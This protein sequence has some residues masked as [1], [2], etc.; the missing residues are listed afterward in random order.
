MADP[1][2]K[3]PRTSQ[4]VP[5][6]ADA[7]S[8]NP[9]TALEK[10]AKSLAALVIISGAAWIV[11]GRAVDA[12]FILDDASS[13][14]QNSSIRKL[15]PLFGDPAVP[16]P[17]RPPQNAATSG[18]PLVNLSLAANY[19]F[20]RLDPGGYHVFNIVVHVFSAILLWAIV[21]RTLCLEFFQHDFDRVARPLAF[22]V[23]LVW[24]IHP[25]QTETVVYVTQ[26]S[27]L[28]VGFFYL[29]TL[30]ASLRYWSSTS[31]SRH[32]TWLILASLAC[33]SGA[34]CKEV[35]VSAPVIVLLF[36]RTFV[37]GSF[38][39]AVRE[40]WPLYLGLLFSWC[41][42]LALNLGWP[43][44]AT[45]GFHLGVPAHAWWLT[46]AK[47]FVT[48]LKLSIYPWPLVLHY[49]FE[50]FYTLGEAWPWVVPVVLLA[51][52]A[53]LLFW[54]R[55]ATGFGLLCI[56]A[57]LSPTLVI[58][59]ITEVAAERRMYLPLAIV[60]AVAVVASY[61]L[62][63]VV[64]GRLKPASGRTRQRK[65]LTVRGDRPL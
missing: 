36:E 6:S 16:G 19:H 59:V 17:L 32:L 3:R 37:A 43:R 40:S 14:S 13:V 22:L 9:A 28:M 54:R 55:T 8:R 24:A 2:K 41:L 58:P 38:H 62:L 21:R 30:Y 7:A 25:L 1:K 47:V 53:L 20:S 57:I 65:L 15:W 4:A 48:Y 34:A 50:Y 56:F 10:A 31:P 44:S 5:L 63:L 23:A 39:K 18:R 46:Q 52:I 35:I 51:A 42:L 64:Q 11:F 12:P 33:L 60:V 45:A 27:E 49:E 26:R 29:S 61:K